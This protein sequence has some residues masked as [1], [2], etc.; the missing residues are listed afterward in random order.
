MNSYIN[1]VPSGIN[2]LD[3]VIGGGFQQGSLIVVAGNPGTGKTIFSATFLYNGIVNY[4]EKGIYVSFAENRET[5]FSNMRALGF[6]FEELE[7]AGSFYFLDMVTAREEAAPAVMET[8]VR[9]VE[10]TGAKRLVIDSFS[11]LAQAFR[12]AHEARIVLHAVLSKI[13][14]FLG[15]TTILVLEVPW[16]EEMIGMGVEEFVADSIIHLKRTKLKD[17]LM[18]E[19]EILKMRGVP[20][21]EPCFVFTLK[22]GFRVF[23]QFKVEYTVRPRRFEPQPDTERCFSTGS[24]DLDKML[25]GGYQRG[26]TVL[27]EIDEHISSF[28]CH[29]LVTPTDHNFLVQGRGVIGIPSRGVDHN[30]I[31]RWFEDGGI[32]RDEINR[33]LRICVKEYHG[34]KPELYIVTFKGEDILD[35]YARYIRAEEELM[36]KTGQPVLSIVGVDTL[37]DIYGVKRTVSF[38]RDCATR[39]RETNGLSIFILKPGYPRLAKILGALADIHLSVMRKHGSILVCGIKPRTNFYVLEMDVSRGYVLPK[40]TPII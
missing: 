38:L 25:G 8:I 28:H 5:F 24:P 7:R 14:R 10:A 31:V 12:N 19:L 15:C 22:D 23:P 32:T 17:R 18:R 2:G 16:G 36:E 4:D 33:L 37:V 26:S 20:I 13:I 3:E 11:A 35:D 1:R 39:V 21:P 27:L 40:L 30:L 6:N 34:L 29:L 9:E